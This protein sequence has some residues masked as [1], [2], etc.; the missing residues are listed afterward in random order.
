MDE[1]VRPS[2]V[3]RFGIFEVDLRAEELR[4]NDTKI[5]LRGQPFQ[6]L[7]MLLEQ[8][9]EVVTR[10]ELQQRLWPQGTFVDFDHS[11]NTAI[12]KIREV[13][14]DS[15]EKPRFVETLP[16]RGYRFIA[17]LERIERASSPEGVLS[18]AELTPTSPASVPSPKAAEG[19]TRLGRLRR[20]RSTRLLWLAAGLALAVGSGLWWVV[21]REAWNLSLPPLQIVKFTSYP[22]IETCPAFSPDGKQIAFVWDGGQGEDQDIYVKS[23]N[24]EVPLQ[25][26]TDPGNDYGPTWSPDGEFIA[27][28]RESHNETGSSSGIYLVPALGGPERRL[29]TR[30][31]ID[32]ISWSPDEKYLAFSDRS[33]SEQRVSLFLLSL[34]TLESH[35]LTSPPAEVPWGGDFRPA[36]SPDGQTVAFIRFS[37]TTSEIYLVP[38]KGGEPKRL[39]FDNRHIRG[40]GW[41]PDGHEI[42]FSSNRN[43][44]RGLW[45]IPASGGTPQAITLPAESINFVSLSLRGHRLAYTNDF[46]D[47]N[48]WRAAANPTASHGAQP[49]QLIFSPDGKKIAFGSTRGSARNGPGGQSEI[50]I[51]DSNGKNPIRLTSGGNPSNNPCWSPDGQQTTFDSYSGGQGDIY[52]IN[53][54]GGTPRR[55]TFEPSDEVVPVWS[56][57]GRWIV[58]RSTRRAVCSCG[59]SRLKA[60]RL[61]SS[62]SRVVSPRSNHTVISLSTILGSMSPASGE[63]PRKV[64][65]KLSWLAPLSLSSAVSPP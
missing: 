18:A 25:L 26:T 11:L 7:A 30:D 41:T 32:S 50:W 21:S 40:L 61:C 47:E 49:T 45:R 33:P 43:F 56:Q 3:V 4:K 23:T 13:L 1:V 53:A 57:D 39:T 55:L 35:R 58:F 46:F 38:V 60:D 19:D 29:G 6:V 2:R 8:P 28:T 24:T 14:G 5:R 37:I 63:S 42:V 52:V 59:R 16:R 9:G 65:K 34:E 20:H 12:N 44:S 51:C 22:G 36:F 10:E 17:P 15:A 31:A 48:L 62:P 27:F 54:A 64:G